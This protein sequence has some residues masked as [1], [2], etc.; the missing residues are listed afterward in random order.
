MWVFEFLECGFKFVGQVAEIGKVALE[1]LTFRFFWRKK[2]W[3]ENMRCFHIGDT[4]AIHCVQFLNTKKKD[5]LVANNVQTT[6]SQ[7]TVNS[8]QAQQTEHETN[9]LFAIKIKK[10]PPWP[11]R[12]NACFVWKVF[13]KLTFFVKKKK[14]DF[15]TVGQ[16]KWG[17]GCTSRND[18]KLHK[19][20]LG[21]LIWNTRIVKKKKIF[22]QTRK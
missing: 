10:L 19:W 14:H 4:F 16:T 18:W 1:E 9:K 2:R 8:K 11:V 6:A 21:L 12:V 15:I 22:F 20:M 5:G 13:L 3:I 7:S 17:F